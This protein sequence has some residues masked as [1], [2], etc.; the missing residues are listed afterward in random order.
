[1]IQRGSAVGGALGDDLNDVAACSAWTKV[2]MRPFTLAPVSA[3]AH[4]GMD[5]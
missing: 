4:R 3:V 2:T 5:G 1:L